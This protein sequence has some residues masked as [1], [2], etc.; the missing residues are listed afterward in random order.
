[1]TCLASLNSEHRNREN[2]LA[3]SA[4]YLIISHNFDLII[5]EGFIPR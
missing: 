1:M 5:T 2:T 4:D 3:L